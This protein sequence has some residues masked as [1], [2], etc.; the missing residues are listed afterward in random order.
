MTSI[1]VQPY[2]AVPT[3]WECSVCL[4]GE[5]E[6]L[7]LR[8]HSSEIGEDHVYHKECLNEAL[9]RK[10]D[11]PL[12]R[13]PL[14][15]RE[16]TIESIDLLDTPKQYMAKVAQHLPQTAAFTASLVTHNLITGSSSIRPA[17]SLVGLLV[18]GLASC[19]VRNLSNAAPIEQSL[20]EPG[21]LKEMTNSHPFIGAVAATVLLGSVATVSSILYYSAPVLLAG[22]AVHHAAD[23]VQ[24]KDLISE[25]QKQ[26]I[27]TVS[28]I[29]TSALSLINP[30]NTLIS[31][32]IGASLGATAEAY[33][34]QSKNEAEPEA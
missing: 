31:L 9:K 30:I 25:E 8:G 29:T 27:Q 16:V 24:E 17:I 10:S 4:D 14:S 22:L 21:G 33:Y 32:G 28:A 34:A 2:Q 18:G 3:D 20:L 11:C 19:A 13:V 5:I 26:C 6:G 12:C 15:C 1:N 7:E 23:K